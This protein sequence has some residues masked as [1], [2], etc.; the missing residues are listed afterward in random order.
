MSA[1]L[2]PIGLLLLVALAGCGSRDSANDQPAQADGLCNADAV[3][4]MRGQFASA[5]TVEQTRLRAG[6]EK[7]RVLAPGDR[8][9]MDFNPQRLNIEIDEAE[10]IQR[11]SCG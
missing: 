8:A 4:D 1:R 5:E 11:L 3:Q 6:A 7:V 2:L 9:T 10:M